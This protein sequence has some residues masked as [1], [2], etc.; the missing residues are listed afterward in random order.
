MYMLFIQLK[1]IAQ[2][3]LRNI[4]RIIFLVIWFIVLCSISLTLTPLLYTTALLRLIPIAPWQDAMRRAGLWC[5]VTWQRFPV[6]LMLYLNRVDVQVYGLSAVKPD[7]RYLLIAN[8]Q[9]WTDAFPMFYLRTRGFPPFKV[10]CKW[11]VLFIPLVNFVALALDFPLMN[12]YKAE[13]LRKNPK[14]RNKDLITTQKACKKI[15]QHPFSLL[16]FCEGTRFTREKHL[17]QQ[18]PYQHLLSPK[19]G[20]MAVAVQSLSGHLDKIL[21]ITIGY[22]DGCNSFISFLAG[23]VRQIIVRIDEVTLPHALQS[24]DYL[25]DAHHRDRF[26]HWLEHHWHEKDRHL[27]DMLK[28]KHKYWHYPK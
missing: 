10:F 27:H 5:D 15:Y 12:R 24:G 14:L 8:H 11:Q 3:L 2:A 18:S 7:G 26:K 25:H 23:D 9:S 28:A 6:W 1:R 20:G 17:K 21:S 16:N 4:R 13:T 22:P 19:A